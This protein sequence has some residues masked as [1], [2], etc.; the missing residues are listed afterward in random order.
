MMSTVR[1]EPLGTSVR[2]PAGTPLR[3]LLF[4]YGVEFP[5]GGKGRCRHCRVRIVEGALTGEGGAAILGPEAFEQGYRLACHATLAGDVTLEIGAWE[6]SILADDR[7]LEIR[8]RAGRA[9]VI[10][11]GT[12][13]LVA[14]L[15]SLETGRVLGVRTA[16]NPQAAHGADV[17]TRVEHALR[18]K[19]LAQLRDAIRGTL[20][21]MAED[22]AAG[23]EVESV[24]LAGNTVMMH[25]FAG[26]DVTPL[27]RAPF[28]PT[29]LGLQEFVATSAG[30]NLAGDPPVR[31]LPAMGGFVGS[32]VLAGIA[33]TGMAER[34]E[35]S[36][37]A[38]L[39]TNGEVVAGNRD[40]ILCASTA[41]GPA[42][43]G[44]GISCGMRAATGAISE[45]EVDGGRLRC[46]VL[47]GGKP[48][49]ICGSGLV[50]AVA[51]GLDLGLI[52]PNGRM[53]APLHLAGALSLTQADV[54]QVQ[55]AK[56]AIA[57]GIRVLLH[58]LGAAPADVRRFY[59]AGAFGN[60]INRASARRIG[61]VE[62]PDELVEP[63]GN[64]ALLG[65][66][67]AV[68]ANDDYRFQ[69]LLARAG[70]VPLGAD[71]E[72]QEAFVD[73]LAFP[74]AAR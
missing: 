15:V 53:A 69:S 66:K 54:R 29:E 57:A 2:A 51:A 32:D 46:H 4:P 42:F 40:R 10:D 70:H 25:L 19:G 58:R 30:W 60:Y 27:S 12:T 26:L 64:T 13:T 16:L 18:A 63:A 38:D 6:S 11:V 21:A 49:G 35:L 73:A 45:V 31:F 5:C 74:A 59:L 48:R 56:G 23:G 14:Q 20:G 34:T 43:E 9:I 3:D 17:M 24:C 61:M 67:M 72:F 37:L 36:L 1:L 55:L 41:A 50:D 71:A 33:A 65:A 52:A 28:D 68:F 7:R 47:G 39:G 44:G 22:L 62:Y 8:P